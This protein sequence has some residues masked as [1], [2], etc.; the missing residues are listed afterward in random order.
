MIEE[1]ETMAVMKDLCHSQRGQNT[2]NTK[3]QRAGLQNKS[4]STCLELCAP[5][6]WSAFYYSFWLQELVWFQEPTSW[7]SE[8]RRGTNIWGPFTMQAKHQRRMRKSVNRDDNGD[9]KCETTLSSE[10]LITIVDKFRLITKI[11]KK[12]NERNEAVKNGIQMKSKMRCSLV[13]PGMRFSLFV[14]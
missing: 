10:L 6:A 9:S 12:P 13:M 11:N 2:K 8:N 1:R 14:Y 3:N 4:H 7:M 5:I